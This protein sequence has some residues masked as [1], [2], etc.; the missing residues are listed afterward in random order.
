MD[1]VHKS[2]LSKEILESFKTL[3]GSNDLIYLDCTLGGGGHALSVAELFQGKVTIIGL[4]QDEKAIER[5]K[6]TLSGKAKEVILENE[7]FRNLDRVLSSHGKDK[8][9]MVLMDLGLSSDELETS[10]KGFTFL[11]DEPLYMTFGDPA[12]YPFTAIDIVNNW[13]EEDI[14][15]VIFG[16]GEE[17]YANRIAKRIAEYRSKTSINTSAELAEIVKGAFPRTFTKP[18]IHP[19]T[20]TFQALRIA[21]NDELN[22]LREAVAKG[23]DALNKN[24]IMAVIS[25]HS[26]EDRIVKTFYKDKQKHD[27]AEVSK[28]PIKAGEDEILENRRS[29]SAKL[30]ILKKL[31]I[32]NNK[33]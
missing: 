32:N 28:K 29:R 16:Y 10:G 12:K 18:K 14:S 20:R 9:D 7:N 25:F 11:K 2:V 33:Q 13:K 27:G 6:R 19:A 23:Y 1:S 26:L 8:V 4:D 17:K 30:R 5:A 3:E 31:E 24:G 22:A 15:N 21:V